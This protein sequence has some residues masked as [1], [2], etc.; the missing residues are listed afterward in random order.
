[1][2]FPLFKQ[3]FKYAIKTYF[4]IITRCPFDLIIFA[5]DFNNKLNHSQQT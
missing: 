5:I 4:I 1:M 3:R 2:R